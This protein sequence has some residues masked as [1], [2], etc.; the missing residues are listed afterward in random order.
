MTS[1]TDPRHFSLPTGAPFKLITQQG[2]LNEL[3]K[4]DENT[5]LENNAFKKW[6]QFKTNFMFTEGAIKKAEENETAPWGR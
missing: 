5:S 6:V 3:V 2:I 1:C 4:D